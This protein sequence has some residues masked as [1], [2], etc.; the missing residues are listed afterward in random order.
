MVRDAAVRAWR[1]VEAALIACADAPS[2]TSPTPIPAPASAP[3]PHAPPAPL[4]YSRVLDALGER[5]CGAVAA[6][7]RALRAGEEVRLR[8]E[9]RRLLG[10]AAALGET[11]WGRLLR[12]DTGS[13]GVGVVTAGGRGVGAVGSGSGA[14][15]GS[16]SGGAAGR[17]VSLLRDLYNAETYQAK[18]LGAAVLEVRRYRYRVIQGGAQGGEGTAVSAVSVSA[19]CMSA[20]TGAS[21]SA[22][23]PTST[24]PT[25]TVWEGTSDCGYYR[26]SRRHIHDSSTRRLASRLALLAGRCGLLHPLLKQAQRAQRAEEVGVAGVGGGRSRGGGT[27]TS[28]TSTSAS[29]AE[30]AGR[31]VGALAALGTA[32]LGLATVVA[33]PPAP[34]SSAPT[35]PTPSGRCAVCFSDKSQAQTQGAQGQTQGQTQ[36]QGLLRCSRCKSVAYCSRE[37]QK[38][39]WKQHQGTCRATIPPATATG[40]GTGTGTA[41]A[42]TAAV[43]LGDP[44]ALLCHAAVLVLEAGGGGAEVSA[45]TPASTPAPTPASTSTSAYS[46]ARRLFLIREAVQLGLAAAQEHLGDRGDVGAGGAGASPGAGEGAHS[47]HSKY[48][49]YSAVVA[50]AGAELLACA[51]YAAGPGPSFPLRYCL[52]PLLEL[53]VDPDA[54][55]QQAARASLCRIALTLSLSSLGALIRANLD[56]VVDRYKPSLSDLLFVLNPPV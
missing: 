1:S 34:A 9:L 41:N 42:A 28:S 8:A 19:T 10:L 12:M 24:T 54:A 3:T 53:A 22:S 48:S 7:G 26:H 27:S 17:L 35:H 51:A 29:R 4:L 50:A 38:Q 45:S 31:R 46:A 44:E 47:Q 14:G 25:P 20:P 16:G 32:L 36:T 2:P 30:R 33:C 37:H 15:S 43:D 55:L 23:T 6:A 18:G 39:H 49:Q 52:Y 5:C 40:T 11:E 13:G 21:A 56:Y